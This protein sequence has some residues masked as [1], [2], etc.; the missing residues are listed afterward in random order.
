MKEGG[1]GLSEKAAEKKEA[2]RRLKRSPFFGKKKRKMDV[3]RGEDF[4]AEVGQKK[5]H[6]KEGFFFFWLRALAFLLGEKLI[7]K[8]RKPKSRPGEE[9]RIF[10]L[11][12]K[13]GKVEKKRG[14][15][16]KGLLSPRQQTWCPIRCGK[17]GG[18]G[19]KRG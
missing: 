9:V 4:A 7:G 1:P 14:K 8:K 6:K 19:E 5:K 16:K 3:K 2:E 17:K 18:K 11:Y 15:K 13:K 10:R 12:R